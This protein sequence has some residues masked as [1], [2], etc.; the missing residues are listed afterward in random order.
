[1]K[2]VYINDRKFFDELKAFCASHGVGFKVES[3]YYSEGM[4]MSWTV[5]VGGAA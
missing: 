1:M 5:V 3:A 2:T 4:R